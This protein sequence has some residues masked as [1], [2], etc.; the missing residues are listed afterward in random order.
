MPITSLDNATGLDVI[1]SLHGRAAAVNDW[2]LGLKSTWQIYFVLYLSVRAHA[3]SISYQ[4]LIWG[5][6]IINIFDVILDSCTT[7]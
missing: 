6:K 4:S 5:V 3:V 2:I 1:N 7:V